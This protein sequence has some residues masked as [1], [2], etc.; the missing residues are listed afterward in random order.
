MTSGFF[1]FIHTPVT[2]MHRIQAVTHI[3][4]RHHFAVPAAENMAPIQIAVVTIP[5]TMLRKVRGLAVLAAG[6][7]AAEG[8]AEN[9]LR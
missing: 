2:D 3:Q 6:S 9:S 8:M 5:W 4:P 7:M 1:R